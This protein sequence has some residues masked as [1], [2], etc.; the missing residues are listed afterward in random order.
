MPKIDGDGSVFYSLAGDIRRRGYRLLRASAPPA[1]NQALT[2]RFG[3]PLGTLETPANLYYRPV[4]PST[5]LQNSADCA[6]TEIRV[7][8]EFP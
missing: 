7:Q 6:P 8:T 4:G 2:S 3:A 1:T 5:I